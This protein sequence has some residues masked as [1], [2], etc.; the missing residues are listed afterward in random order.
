[1]N[2][3]LLL[4]GSLI[5]LLTA[6]HNSSPTETESAPSSAASTVTTASSTEAST[7]V[8]ATPAETS[9][10]TAVDA[11]SGATAKANPA[12]FNGTLMI[13]P[14][15]LATITLPMDGIVRHIYLLP[16]TYTQRGT[17][18]AA[19]QNPEFIELQQSFLDSKAQLDFLQ[20][21]YERQTNLAQAEVA[22]Q[23]RLQQAKADYLSMK[24]RMQA[25]EAQLQL[26]GVDTEQLSQSGIQPL[27]EIKAPISGYVSQLQANQGSYLH[28][29]DPLC[30]IID[31]SHLLI[32][33]IAYEK[34]LTGLHEGDQ[35]QFEV[36]GLGHTHFHATLISIGQQV[37][38]TNRS[39]ELLGRV[40]E[41]HP[42]FRP[43]MYVS[44]KLDTEP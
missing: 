18:I 15:Q 3:S 10:S 27:L 38:E 13:P 42:Q 7:P 25:T 9:S 40:K 20:A 30:N 11:L 26:L 2:K 4:S 22:S 8:T 29:G 37:D 21:E 5:L 12:A 44:A 35:L 17:R 31:K 24:S 36:N 1:M 19:L 33:L 39:I 34:D 32:R 16:G 28:A 14:Q 6:C 43:G 41:S 23:K